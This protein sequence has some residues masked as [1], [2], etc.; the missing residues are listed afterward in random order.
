VTGY[1]PVT[2]GAFQVDQ[3]ECDITL[4]RN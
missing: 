4:Q 3:R 1:V 2:Q